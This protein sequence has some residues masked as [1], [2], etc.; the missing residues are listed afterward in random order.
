MLNQLL[1]S[2]DLS[3]AQHE[4]LM[5]ILQQDGITQKEL[6]ARL[7]VVKSN[8]SALLKKLETRGLVKRRTDPDDS[9]NKL[10]SLTQSGRKLVQKSFTLQNRI[11][12]VMAA[13]LSEDDLENIAD[14]M[15]KVDRALDQL[16]GD[17]KVMGSE[18]GVRVG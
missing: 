3:L 12:E 11:V 5:T 10:I 1:A 8:I 17:S 7:H 4:I 18:S 13:E 2:V 14:V 15:G 6:S 9:R 16:E